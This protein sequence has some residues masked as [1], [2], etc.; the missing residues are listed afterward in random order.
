MSLF[1]FFCYG[2]PLSRGLLVCFLS[3]SEPLRSEAAQACLVW[4][5]MVSLWGRLRET[6]QDAEGIACLVKC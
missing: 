6:Q 3:V 4:D 1:E 2:L 5:L